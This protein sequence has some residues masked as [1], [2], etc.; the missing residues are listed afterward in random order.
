LED[1]LR[2]SF[3]SLLAVSAL[4]AWP[5]ILVACKSETQ[6]A[7]TAS[8]SAP[9]PQP[10]APAAAQPQPATPAAPASTSPSPE[11]EKSSKTAT[12]AP[13]QSPSATPTASVAGLPDVDAREA[14]GSK[15]APIVMETFSDY[16]CPACKQLYMNSARQLT[17][18][19]VATGK[20]YWI[21][22]DFPLPG[23]AY[24]RV[25]ARY[26]RAAAQL[27][28]LEQVEEVL[29]Q[30]QEKWEQTGDV[31]GTLAKAFSAADMG[32]IRNLTK[33]PVIEASIEKDLALGRGYSVNQTPTT[34]VHYKG[35]TYPIVGIVT[36]ENLR[37]FL[38]QLLSM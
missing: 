5:A 29:F 13:A 6:P 36:Y 38:D 33:N 3:L 12:S 37:Q 25:A 23:H 21:H 28:K 22:R 20:V 31:D 26:G 2:R 8:A 18:N 27:G 24:S 32:K 10:A 19:Y 4:L 1:C 14:R 35:Q 11:T 15:S 34:I 7:E 9:Q 16:Q 30:N 17:D